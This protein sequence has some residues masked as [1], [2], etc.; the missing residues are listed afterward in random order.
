M[1]HGPTDVELLRRNLPWLYSPLNFFLIHMDRKSSDKDRADVRELLHG[2]DNARM[3]EPAQSV[4][5]GG[6]SI[7]LTALFGLST[8]VE[9]SRD[10][11][12]FINLRYPKSL[13]PTL[14]PLLV[15]LLLPPLLTAVSV[16]GKIS[17]RGRVVTSWVLAPCASRA[18]L[19]CGCRRGTPCVR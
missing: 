4:S 9:W 14:S 15:L 19:R 13:W 7:T 18:H 17:G 2:L 8:L 1:A 5:W 3:L 10:W 16:V 12:Y 6:Y 11:D